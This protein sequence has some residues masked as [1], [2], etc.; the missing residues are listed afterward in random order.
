MGDG[1]G[2]DDGR[3][4]REMERDFESRFPTR[5]MNELRVQREIKGEFIPI[6]GREE[7]AIRLEREKV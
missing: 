5:K 6:G 1:D 4:E 7:K 2:G 3:D